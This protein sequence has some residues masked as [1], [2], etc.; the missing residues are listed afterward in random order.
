[1]P[2]VSVII[3]T[4][5]RE[6]LL[7]NR[8]LP[9]VLS[10]PVD[11]EVI[12]VADGMNHTDYG[13]MVDQ[14]SDPRVRCFNI[15]RQQYPD[16]FWGVLAV[17]ARNFGMDNATGEWLSMLDDD[18]E[19]MDHNLDFLLDRASRVDADFIYGRSITYK[20]GQMT[21]QVYGSWPPGD[22]NITHGAF[23]MRASLPYRYDLSCYERGLNADAD[24][25]TRMYQGGVK[26]EFVPR[27]IH[28]YHRNWP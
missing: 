28:K 6:H 14:I 22:G 16:N 1:M 15:E 21:G 26:F 24:L 23:I 12:V 25:W 2:Q 20:N 17:N 7:L 11:L 27:I 18:D 19:M 5:N 3:P 10:Q 9:S 8:S 13:P 4:Y